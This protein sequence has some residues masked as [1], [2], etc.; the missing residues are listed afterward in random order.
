[1]WSPEDGALVTLCQMSFC[2]LCSLAWKGTRGQEPS[3]CCSPL[4]LLVPIVSPL[5]LHLLFSLPFRSLRQKWLEGPTVLCGIRNPSQSITLRCSCVNK[6]SCLLTELPKVMRKQSKRSGRG[7][8]KPSSCYIH[9]QACQ[10]F[11]GGFTKLKSHRVLVCRSFL[12][13]LIIC[14]THVPVP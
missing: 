4:S 12:F 7:K 13:Y 2:N 6:I 3:F 1:M 5:S 9:I 8:R 11:F 10:V 14:D